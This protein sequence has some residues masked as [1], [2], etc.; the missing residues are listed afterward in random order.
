M[1]VEFDNSGFSIKDRCTRE[2]ILCSDSHGD[3]YP[4]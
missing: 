1:T 4:L 2:V 3:L